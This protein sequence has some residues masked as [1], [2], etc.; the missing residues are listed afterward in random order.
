MRIFQLFIVLFFSTTVLSQN[1]GLGVKLGG[2]FSYL[3]SEAVAQNEFLFGVHG[4]VYFPIL[5]R[6]RLEVQPEILFS[7]QGGGY[8]FSNSITEERLNY[9]SIPIAAKIYFSNWFNIQVGPQFSYLLNAR[10]EYNDTEAIDV[11]DDYFSHDISFLLGLGYDDHRGLD[12]TL[13]Y[14]LGM[15]TLLRED[16]IIY[17]RNRVV[18]LSL[19]YRLAQFSNRR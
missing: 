8:Q 17:P 12:I 13:R 10:S 19:G 2:N 18:Q 6:T 16:D 11:S 3:A 15:T 7:M 14:L 4:G 1:S 5:V 9:L